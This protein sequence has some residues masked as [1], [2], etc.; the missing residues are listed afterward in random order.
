M[1][2]LLIRSVIA[3]AAVA[4]CQQR[5]ETEDGAELDL[6]SLDVPGDGD[7]RSTIAMSSEALLAP[8]EAIGVASACHGNITCSGY[9]SC[10]GWSSY[11]SCGTPSSCG[12]PVCRYRYCDIDGCY[13]EI[14]PA[15]FEYSERY[16]V[17]FDGAGNQCT[18]YQQLN[19]KFCGC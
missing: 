9:G 4:G 14:E 11:Y 8:E 19:T 17:C 12:A 15:Y 1:K 7:E 18:E 5:A 3:A 10:A 16:R 6:A 2:N 13:F